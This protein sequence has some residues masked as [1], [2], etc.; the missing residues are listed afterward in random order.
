MVQDQLV[1]YISSQM[2][3]GVSRDAIKAA[4][5][6]VGWAAADVEDTLKKVG[7]ANKPAAPAAAAPAGAMPANSAFT[8]TSSGSMST[9]TV[10]VGGAPKITMN[11]SPKPMAVSMGGMQKSSG[12]Q[13]IRVSDLISAS[14]AAGP[15]TKT[16]FASMSPKN[17]GPKIDPMTD[18]IM[19]VGTKTGTP[20][21]GRIIMIVGIVVIL[22][23]AGLAGF[24][25]FQNSGLTAKITALSN[26]SVD[27][28]SRLSSLNNQFQA[29]NASNTILAAQVVSLASQNVDLWNNLSFVAGPVGVAAGASVSSTVSIGGTLAGG[30]S[31]YALTTAHGVVVYVSNAKDAKVAAALTPFVGSTSTVQL[32]GTHVAGSPYITVTAV[33]GTVLQ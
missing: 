2:K 19:G 6:G 8:S 4:L 11:G 22:A 29:L 15:A 12:A 23:L 31:S 10:S 7:E 16:T 33:N 20:R 3:A 28:T 25:Y 17:M 30:K 13:S 9:G 24:L 1:E 5:V 21:G 14:T 18:P 32:T 26:E 27:V